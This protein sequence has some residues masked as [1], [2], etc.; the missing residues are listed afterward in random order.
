[1]SRNQINFTAGLTQVVVPPEV[2]TLQNPSSTG[3]C[4]C[5]C[6]IH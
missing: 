1:M 3:V 6:Y 4:V 5:V 2:E